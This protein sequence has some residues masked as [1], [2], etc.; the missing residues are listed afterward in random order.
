MKIGAASPEWHGAA[1]THTHTHITAHSTLTRSDAT[2][3]EWHGTAGTH[4]HNGTFH[5]EEYLVQQVQSGTELQAH[6]HNGTFHTDE[7]LVQQVQSG[8]E[9]QAHTQWHIPH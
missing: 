8:T 4:T 1:S 9:L 2:S 7:Y 6:T 3:P 5:T